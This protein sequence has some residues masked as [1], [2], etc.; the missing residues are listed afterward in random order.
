MHALLSSQEL[1]HDGVVRLEAIV[2]DLDVGQRLV[3]EYLEGPTLQG[4]LARQKKRGPHKKLYTPQ[5]GAKWM[6]QLAS[7]L[8]YMHSRPGGRKI[9]HRQALNAT[10]TYLPTCLPPYLPAHL[11]AYLS[12]YLP[13]YLPAHLPT[14]LPTYLPTCLPAYLPASLPT[15]LFESQPSGLNRWDAA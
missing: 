6:L 2:S 10:P 13:T 15:C 8:E 12:T 3:E 1:R 11:P 14:Y 7:A 9:I 5:Q 4:L